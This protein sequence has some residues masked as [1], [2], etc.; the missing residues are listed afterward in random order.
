MT[1][2]LTVKVFFS[3]YLELIQIKMYNYLKAVNMKSFFN[4]LFQYNN[5]YNQQL[6]SILAANEIRVSERCIRLISHILNAHQIWNCKFDPGHTPYEIWQVHPINTLRNIDMQNFNM[7][8]QVLAQYDLDQII[9]YTTKAGKPFSN[10]VRDILFQVIN[11][12]TYHRAQLATE[13][14]AMG[15][16]PLLT[17]YI[18]Y[19]M[20]G[21]V[22]ENEEIN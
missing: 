8:I 6:I 14:R 18:A 22:I 13:F 19:K 10:T 1:G 11:H 17:D 15:L 16:E 9:D 3:S 4:E 5:Y 2:A 20:N 7:S 12:S 21:P